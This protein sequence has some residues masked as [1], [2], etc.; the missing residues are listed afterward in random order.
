MSASL[1]CSISAQVG[2]L[3]LEASFEI[4]PG[5]CLALVGPNGAG[6]TSLVRAV[7]GLLPLDGG[8]VAY[9]GRV[10]EEPAASLRLPPRDRSVG[11]MFQ[12]LSLFPH[13]SVR[14][15]VA[16]PLRSR[17]MAAAEARSRAARILAELGAAEVEDK[18]SQLSGG[19][20]QRVALARALVAD[21]GV[22]LLDEP[23]SSI[24]AAYRPELRRTLAQAIGGSEHVAVLVTH[25]VLD[26]FSLAD[27]LCVIEEGRSVQ[28][29]TADEIRT[30]P[31]SE[32]A[33]SIAGLNYLEGVVAIHDGDRILRCPGGDLV[34]AD[35]SVAVGSSVLA[36]VH[37]H[38][39]T[40]GLRHEETSA[41]NLLRTRVTG[42]ENLHERVRVTLDA[43]FPL[44]AEITRAAREDLMLAA[45]SEIWAS[46]K[47]TQID[48]YPA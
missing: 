33:A 35:E 4:A 25:D 23:L 42:I 5:E 46:I 15:N 13:M 38:A 9:G 47:A 16:Y 11:M 17:G 8:R 40:L 21:P 18:P 32:Y 2:E 14:D 45:G 12:S 3:S 36:T 39:I 37:P 48:V 41:R 28:V 43:G 7:A 30:R 10:W 34:I 19:E 31:R 1:E 6:K 27:R 24:D 26:A 20:A 44:T 22:L 29:G